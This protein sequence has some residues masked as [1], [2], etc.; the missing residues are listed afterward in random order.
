MVARAQGCSLSIVIYR[1]GASETQ[2]DMSLRDE[3]P[4]ESISTSQSTRLQINP[5][6][7]IDHSE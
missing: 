2:Y 6:V 7:H 1:H 5:I 3:Q 4:V